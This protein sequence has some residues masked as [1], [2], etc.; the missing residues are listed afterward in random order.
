M[1]EIDE[2]VI[3]PRRDKRGRRFGFVRF[4]NVKDED[5]L[6][7]KL[8]NIVLEGRKIYVNLSKFMRMIKEEPSLEGGNEVK[9]KGNNV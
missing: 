3:S 8:D 9:G 1:G 6:A 7:I 2:V 5:P 4:M